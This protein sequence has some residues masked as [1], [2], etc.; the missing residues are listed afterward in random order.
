MFLF[1]TQVLKQECNIGSEGRPHLTNIRLHGENCL[2]CY[3]GQK[4]LKEVTIC[5]DVLHPPR[6]WPIQRARTYQKRVATAHAGHP[7]DILIVHSFWHQ[8]ASDDWTKEILPSD[9]MVNFVTL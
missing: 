1:H 7:S 4:D 8:N 2:C 6:T 5:E 9:I 3:L